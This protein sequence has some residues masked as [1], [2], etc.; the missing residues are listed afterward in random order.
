MN[1]D[2]TTWRPC[3]IVFVISLFHTHTHT[4]GIA[5]PSLMLMENGVSVANAR[6]N[7]WRSDS[8]PYWP[9]AAVRYNTIVNQD[10]KWHKLTRTHYMFEAKVQTMPWSGREW[11]KRKPVAFTTSRGAIVTSSH[12]RQHNV[13][14]LKCLPPFKRVTKPQITEKRQQQ[15]NKKQKQKPQQQ[16]KKNR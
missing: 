4:L 16:K 8:K 6:F 3:R 7:K 15:N 2:S 12:V 14:F 11:M 1:S 9:G 10:H 5:W 13:D